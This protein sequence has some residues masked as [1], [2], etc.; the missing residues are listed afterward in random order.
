MMKAVIFDMDGVLIDSHP[1]HKRAWRRFLSSVDRDVTDE[2]L[3]FVLDGR[4]REDILRHFFGELTSQQVAAF[5]RSKEEMFREEASEVVAISGVVSFLDELALAD[6]PVALASSASASRVEFI[7]ERLQLRSRFSAIVTGDDVH[8]G[9]PDP[10]IFKKAADRI[11]VSYGDSLVI[12]DAV[13]G[14]IAARNAGMK[15]MAIA[16]N[17]R[18]Q[19]LRNAGAAIVVADFSS[20]TMDRLA[21]LFN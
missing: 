7:L 6:I 5:G 21:A 11:N 13:S 4:K 3:D 9:K 18:A 12:E 8:H 15:C 10:T 2:Q 17:G 19:A 16:S 20:V 1:V 14:V